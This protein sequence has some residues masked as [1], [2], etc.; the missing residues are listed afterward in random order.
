MAK[1]IFLVNGEIPTLIDCKVIRDNLNGI[2]LKDSSDKNNSK[3]DRRQPK[4]RSAVIG[5]NKC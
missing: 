3:S 4:V 1:G 5:H 2:T